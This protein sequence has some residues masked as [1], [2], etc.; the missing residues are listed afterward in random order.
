M[1]QKILQWIQDPKSQRNLILG[2]AI[3]L[4]ILLWKGCGSRGTDNIQNDI[5]QN[6][7]ALKDSIRTY[8]EKNGQIVEEKLA[9]I[10]E[11]GN[12]RSINNDLNTTVKGLKDHP[13]VVIKSQIKLIHDTIS[14][15]TYIQD[16][17]WNKRKTE[18]TEGIDW[19]YTSNDSTNI[20]LIS[21]KFT[22]IVDSNMNLRVSE[23]HII[24]DEFSVPIITGLTE[25]KQGLLQIIVTS[26]NKGFS[27]TSIE[28][29]LIDPSKSE[30]LKKYFPEKHWSIGP[31][32][33]YGIYLDGKN[34]RVGT[35]IQVGLGLQYKIWDWNFKKN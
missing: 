2:I 25:N 8:K 28:G 34:A 26:P 29:A 20:R 27:A 6:T 14:I 15:P 7:A 19:N 13:L 21:G 5:V 33:G 17:N 3:L 16:E 35:A 22:A 10:T 9:L 4:A 18:L 12:L 1:I 24:R 30:V 31:Y 32:A 11:N 23:V